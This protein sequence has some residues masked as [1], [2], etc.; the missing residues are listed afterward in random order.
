MIID[1]IYPQIIGD[2]LSFDDCFKL[3]AKELDISS[4]MSQSLLDLAPGGLRG[5]ECF[6][7]K[8]KNMWRYE[9][10][11]PSTLDK[12][13][14]H[15][16]GTQMWLPMCVFTK[17]ILCAKTNLKATE[18]CQ[19]TQRLSDINKHKDV[20][21]EMMPLLHIDTSLLLD[22][23]FEVSGYGTGDST[24]DW[25]L[26]TTDGR[27]ILIDVKNRMYDIYLMLDQKNITEPLHDHTKL[28]KSSEYKLKSIDPNEILQGVWITTQIKQEISKLKS[29]FESLDKT[30]V[31]FCILGDHKDDAFILTRRSEDEQFLRRL[32]NLKPS[33]RFTYSQTA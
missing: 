25:C 8:F 2:K 33:D 15:L 1:Q 23:N 14:K 30:K 20:L 12:T 11:L 3:V 29:A 21:A 31:H 18:L 32:L 24:I 7:D 6:Y 17:I 5:A 22:T 4:E 16:W 13:K 10:G 19:Y 26:T 28:F 9:Y 27:K